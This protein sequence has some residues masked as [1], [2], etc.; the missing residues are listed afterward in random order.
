MS[1]EVRIS[2]IHGV[3]VQ[4]GVRL[5]ELAIKHVK[6]QR[7]SPATGMAEMVPI[8]EHLM[9]SMNPNPARRFEWTGILRLEDE[10][11]EQL[12]KLNTVSFPVS[13]AVPSA[14]N[15]IVI[16]SRLMTPLLLVVVAKERLP[17]ARRKSWSQELLYS[18]LTF[19]R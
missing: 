11:I 17:S 13:K 2:K 1:F 18:F 3:F 8:L 7:I 14:K 16:Q 10:A 4:V 6:I 5:I 19:L 12:V 9:M 15:L